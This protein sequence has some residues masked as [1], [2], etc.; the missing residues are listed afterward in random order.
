[1]E[2]KDYDYIVTPFPEK[3]ARFFHISYPLMWF[4]V[5]LFLGA[6]HIFSCLYSHE[7]VSQKA[8]LVVI[9]LRPFF[10]AVAIVRFSKAL[11]EFTPS[12]FSFIDWPDERILDWYESELR[13]IFNFKWMD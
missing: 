1:M 9:A 2:E 8:L 5:S 12:L 11:E 4:I 7:T 3:I 6:L 10:I 13:S